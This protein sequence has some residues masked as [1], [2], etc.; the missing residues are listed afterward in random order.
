[1]FTFPQLSFCHS[2]KNLWSEYI[3]QYAQYVAENDKTVK[4]QI[5]D[6]EKH[7]GTLDKIEAE[8]FDE[9]RR[10]DTLIRAYRMKNEQLM[11]QDIAWSNFKQYITGYVRETMQFNVDYLCSRTE[12]FGIQQ[13]SRYA[14][15]GIDA[16]S[17]YGPISAFIGSMKSTGLAVEDR[18]SFFNQNPSHPFTAFPC[19]Q[20]ISNFSAHPTVSATML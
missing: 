16:A 2:N 15:A 18:D 9:L 5:R 13:L 7:N 6:E 10:N 4:R 17:T 3:R 12:F 19:A 8:W 11:T 1:M 14:K 20:P